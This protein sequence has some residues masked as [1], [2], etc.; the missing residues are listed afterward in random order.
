MSDDN[1]KVVEFN[2]P[3][4]VRTNAVEENPKHPPHRNYQILTRDGNTYH[5]DGYLIVTGTWVGV[6]QGEFA[7]L[8]FVIPLDQLGSVNLYDELDEELPF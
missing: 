7:E 6:A 2:R 3:K 5:S 8:Q 4:I 1:D